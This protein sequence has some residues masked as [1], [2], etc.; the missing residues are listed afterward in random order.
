MAKVPAIPNQGREIREYILDAVAAFR[1]GAATVLVGGELEECGVDPALIMG[2]ALHAAGADPLT[3][4]CLVAK[5]TDKA[6]FFLEGNR[7]P[8]ATDVGVEYGISKDADGDWFVD[9]AKN[10]GVAGAALRVIVEDVDTTR[11]LYEVRVLA[12][13]RQLA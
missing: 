5:A 4:R 9:T 1:E 10:A 7:A 11:N 6:T 13:N 2:F 12:A 3:D 8:L